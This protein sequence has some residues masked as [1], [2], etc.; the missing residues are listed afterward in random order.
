[1]GKDGSFIWSALIHVGTRMWSD[2]PENLH[3][4]L[5]FDEGV[6]HAITER[7]R[8]IGMNMVI[9]DIGESLVYPSH[10]ELA[11][12]G[13][14]SPDKLHDEV[15]RLR[16]M[17]LEPIPKL[18]FSSTHDTWLGEYSRMTSSHTL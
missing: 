9:L 7:M 4:D 18:N 1:M 14:W 13:S 5:Q 11:I 3:C 16:K 8:E 15:V 2:R 6:Y 12:K 10:P 17:G